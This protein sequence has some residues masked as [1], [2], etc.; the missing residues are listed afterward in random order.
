[1]NNAFP[2]CESV[3][4]NTTFILLSGQIRLM[5]VFTKYLFITL[6]NKPNKYLSSLLGDS[7][8]FAAFSKQNP[9]NQDNTLK[10]Q[11]IPLKEDLG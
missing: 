11:C 8:T 9:T 3:G 7:D 5:P 10:S 2:F 1:M 6:P 4:G